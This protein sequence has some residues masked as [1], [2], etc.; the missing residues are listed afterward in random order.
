MKYEK[1]VINHL[2]NGG[3]PYNPEQSYMSCVSIFLNN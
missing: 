3:L 2:K 1:F